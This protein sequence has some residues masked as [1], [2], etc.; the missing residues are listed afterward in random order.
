[1]G[2]IMGGGS[3][4]N[5]NAY[6]VRGT[7]ESVDL[8]SRSIW[9]TNVSGYTSMLS[10][11]GSGNGVRVY[12]DDRTTVAHQG[13]TYRPED[14]E[15]GDEV[16]VRVDE[17][18][19]SLLAESVTVT[20]DATNG[21]IYGSGSGSS[22]PSSSSMT[23]RGTVSYLDASRRTLELNRGYGSAT[24]VEFENSTPVYFNNQTY[25]VS[26][27]ERGD[28]IEIRGRDLGNNRFLATD[29]TVTRN[30]SGGSGGIYGGGSTSNQSSTIRGTVAYVD[31]SRRTIELE[32]TNWINGFN[33]GTSGSSRVIVQYGANAGVDVNGSL[34]PISGLER[35]DVIEVQVQNT[36]GSMLYADRLWLVRDVRR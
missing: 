9:L 21:S 27:L 14:L 13:S 35:G 19:N 28:E 23:L 8:N 2:D 5:N 6:E 4:N 24:V 11:G 26:D 36:S 25:R 22:Y 32:S 3:G 29:I 31:T 34:Q 20:H 15:R 1:M 30:V 17:Q 10:N 12:Y 33:R 16:V 18:G 7:V